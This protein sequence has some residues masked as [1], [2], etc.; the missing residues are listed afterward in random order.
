MKKSIDIN[1]IKQAFEEI[2]PKYPVDFAY[3][4][5]SQAKGQSHMESDIDIALGLGKK[6]KDADEE[7][8]FEILPIISNKLD[9]PSETL[10]I[11]DFNRL[12]LPV[13]FRAVRDGKLIYCADI[14]Q[15]RK[16]TLDAVAKYHDEESFFETAAQKFFERVGA[17]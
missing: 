10:D 11:K 9:I 14:E 3:L 2:L 4:Y 7:V 5:G 6:V 12:P 8:I 16:K 13:R 1:K 17:S 15:H